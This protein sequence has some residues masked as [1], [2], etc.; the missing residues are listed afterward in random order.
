MRLLSLRGGNWH[1]ARLGCVLG[2][3]RRS[4]AASTGVNT[5]ASALASV[6]G[7]TA[8]GPVRLW[9]PLVLAL[10][11]AAAF[12][13]LPAAACSLAAGY[14][15]PTNL[16]LAA[17]AHAV[18]LA[19]VVGDAEIEAQNPQDQQG[20]RLRPLRMLK[21]LM[22][23]DALILPG[24]ALAADPGWE[25]SD[26]LELAAP[27]VDSYSGSCIR[28]R[29]APRQVALF[30]LKREDGFWR[31]AGAAYSRWAEDVAS[32]DAP[33]LALAGHYIHAARLPADQQRALLEDEEEAL[34]AREDDVTAQLMADDIARQ[35]AGLDRR[36]LPALPPA[37]RED[38]GEPAS[39]P[40]QPSAVEA[41]L[42]AMRAQAEKRR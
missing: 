41:A 15:A 21:G 9:M 29:F 18:V 42:D 38:E 5:G 2:R 4:A 39:H 20:I 8:R 10:G 12:P 34:R 19:E 7:R 17:S 31:P 24:M 28:H 3:G 22:P 1:A 37:G 26:P 11:T 30:F 13:A 25:A 6:P 36:P 27:H 40:G 35:L 23:Q 33:W 16:E 14:V 32:E